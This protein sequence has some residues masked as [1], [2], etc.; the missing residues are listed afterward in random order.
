MDSRSTE[1][2]FGIAGYNRLD[3]M[4]AER[5]SVL[6]QRARGGDRDAI[7]ELL[8]SAKPQ[9]EQVARSLLG[10][11]LRARVRTSDLLQSTYVE[12]LSSVRQFKGRTDEAFARWVARIL[13]N[14]VRDAVKFHGAQRRSKQKESSSTAVEFLPQPSRGASP[15]ASAAFS[16]ELVLIGRAMQSLPESYRRVILLRM[17]PGANHEV[18]AKAM[19]RSVGA[20]RVLLARAR[21]A[22]IVEMDRL[23]ARR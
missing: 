5:T 9:L 1:S 16:D 23:R 13:E 15:S 10:D 2:R 3:D 8:L 18:T 19:Q 7:G 11:E 4:A 21:A 20:T 12:V 6:L 22:L 14:N 17:K